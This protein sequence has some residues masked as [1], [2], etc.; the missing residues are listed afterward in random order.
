[1]TSARTPH[2]MGVKKPNKRNAQFSRE[3]LMLVRKAAGLLGGLIAAMA[4]LGTA[5]PADAQEK[6]IKIGV[7]AAVGA[8]LQ[9]CS[10]F[11]RRW[12]FSFKVSR[13]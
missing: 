6:K 5:V 7:C 11:V 2:V 12:L 8:Y 3:V 9:S 13:R 10:S 1:M 4:G